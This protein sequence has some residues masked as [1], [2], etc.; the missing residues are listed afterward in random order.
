MKKILSLILLA[1]ALLCAAAKSNAQTRIIEIA[2]VREL[3]QM[4][5]QSDNHV[6]MKAG[7]YQMQDYLTPEIIE[8]TPYADAVNRKAM[9]LFSGS[10]NVFDLTGVTI[11]IATS[12]LNDFNASI[13][14]IQIN[15]SNNIIKGLTITDIGNEPPTSK[16]ARS[17]V[18]AGDNNKIDGVTLNMSGSHPYGDGDLLGKGS[19]NVTRLNKHSGMLIEGLNDTIINCSIY[20]RSF[21]HL[22]FVQGGRNVYFENCYAEAVVRATDEMLA[23]SSGVAFDIGFKSVYGNYDGKK[24]IA[25]GYVKSLSECGFRNY[26]SGG[27][28]RNKTGAITLINCR[29]KNTR[30][31]FALTRMDED[32]IIEN[33][34]AQGCE[35]GYS[36]TGV[37]VR[38]SRGDAKHGPLFNL[39]AAATPCDVELELMPASSEYTV[40]SLA[41]IA[42]GNHK[43]KID[44]YNGELRAKPLPI[45][46][47]SGRPS[48]NNGF[49]PF[50]D[51]KAA[52]VELVNSSGMPIILSAESSSCE[53]I[54][55]AA[56]IDKGVGNK[57]V[58]N[59]R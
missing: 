46:I 55:D 4:A 20:S 9:I 5:A 49:T 51:A 27:A 3:A 13:N 52:N 47:G 41:T 45:M 54:S 29:T 16:G 8:N 34:E 28:E 30:I 33:C 24:L 35:V 32:M 10:G 26:G 7:V 15:G 48:A 1:V 59:K 36:L 37:T 39:G 31:G 6:R 40:H 44:K 58:S 2:S 21:G 17:F 25:S 22:F 53:V 18:V 19:N 14:E 11:E 43:I 50:K 42:G 23:E 56:I 57:V 38:K 12:L